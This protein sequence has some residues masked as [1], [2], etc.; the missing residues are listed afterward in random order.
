MVTKVL[1]KQPAKATTKLSFFSFVMQNNQAD[2]VRLLLSYGADPTVVNGK[3]ENALAVTSN[4]HTKS[5]YKD[6]LFASI[7]SHDMRMTEKL[8]MAATETDIRDN[9]EKL[10]TPLHWAVS[11]LNKEAIHFLTGTIKFY[12]QYTV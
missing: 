4:K 3:G 7:A 9:L 6:A 10:N 2:M 1:N 5:A 8:Y 12:G 11:F